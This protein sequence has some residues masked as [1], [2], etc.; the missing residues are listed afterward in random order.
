MRSAVVLAFLAVMAMTL[1]LAGCG[2]L[3]AGELKRQV[4]IV[5]STSAEGGVLAERVAANDIRDSFTRVHAAELAGQMD[6]TQAKL[7]E[8]D[9]QGDVT[10]QLK[11]SVRE[12][13][14]LAAD[15][16]DALQVLALQPADPEAAHQAAQQLHEA[17][18]AAQDLS[19][20]L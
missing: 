20:R 4:D 14:Q 18:T 10:D 13:I 3:S 19:A 15:A 2:G 7:Q 6:H 1:A 17:R 9:E 16:A 11:A 5:D 12:T 8:T